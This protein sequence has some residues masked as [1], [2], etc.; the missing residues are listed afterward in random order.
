ADVA[1]AGAL[2][3][4]ADLPEPQR[5][6]LPLPSLEDALERVRAAAT[7]AARE[8][9]APAAAFPGPVTLSYSALRAYRACPRR[10][11]L[12]HVLR[13][14]EVP[15][16]LLAPVARADFYDAAALGTAV[17]AALECYPDPGVPR[18]H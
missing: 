3:T 6:P 14:P 16:A 13:L 12:A 4:R 9:P 7:R 11:Q 17:H 15:A 18:D 8:E 1:A 5:P 2:E 10:Y